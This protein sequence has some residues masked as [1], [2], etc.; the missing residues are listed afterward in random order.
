MG[1]EP[2]RENG[3]AGFIKIHH[4]DA[5]L[6]FGG[7]HDRSMD[8]ARDSLPQFSLAPAGGDA[9]VGGRQFHLD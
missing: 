5:P 2:G 3:T 1:P 9:G 6:I 7:F 4:A 8:P